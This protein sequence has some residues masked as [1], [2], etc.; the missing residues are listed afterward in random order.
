MAESLK[1]K[2]VK[3][4][5]WSSLERFSVQG[6]Q[7]VVM[8]IMARI[9]T[10]EDYGL[11]GMLTI[12]IAVSQSLIDSG[13]SQALIRKQ[14]RS[15]ID[16]S[17]VFYFNIGVGIILYLILFFS[18][19]LI[20][21]FYSEPQL[22][23]ITRVIGLSLV[24]N[25][26]GVVQRALLTVKLD[27]KTQ[28]KAS[29]VGAIL[30][31]IIGISMAYTGFGIWA[32][33]WQQLSNLAIVTIILWILSHWKPVWVYSWKSFKEL[34]GFGSKLLASGLL[35]TIF[36]NLYLI[37]IGK[38]FRASDLGYY[39]RAQQFTD[40]ASSNITGIF[41]R[42]T[43]PVLCTI[44]D[45]DTRLSDVYRRL[46]RTSAFIIFP[47]MM[48]L[49]AVAKPMVISFLTEKWLFSAIL[50]QI[51]CFSQM[52]YPVHAINLNLLQVKGRSDLFLKL[53]IIKKIIIVIMLCITLPLGI[54]PMC[55]GM[56]ATSIIALIINTH[57]TGKLIHLGFFKQMKDLLPTLIL[58][59]ATGAIVYLTVTYIPMESWLA[60]S[61]G[62]IEGMLLYAGLA[63]LLRFSEFKELLFV[64]RKK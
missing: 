30:S 27:F 58:S 54:I 19:P 59:I 1:N 55:I 17:T 28:A 13:F 34:F 36:R 31:G 63:K 35:D 15:E 10:P 64:I 52:W 57:Y 44:Q 37:I 47:L 14:D 22:T 43:Y 41:Q 16:N 25:S 51:L 62:V 4:T 48:G 49:A 6:I 33:V 12:F 46:L 24:F 32:I 7:F 38:F 42:V 61:V 9:L 5:V 45:D 23:P 26:L 11:I 8:I 56:I 50:I 20:A 53:E 60:L 40:F 3:G 39:T 21:A 2:T 18:A 29:F